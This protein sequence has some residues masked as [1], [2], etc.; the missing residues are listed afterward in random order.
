MS[1]L[2][3]KNKVYSFGEISEIARQNGM[4]T[5]DCLK[6][7]NMISLEGFDGKHLS[8]T[9]VFEFRHLGNYLFKLKW[10]ELDW[11]KYI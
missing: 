5:I 8:G 6:D 7:D 4:T 11:K 9:N 10:F 3:S 2:F 1:N